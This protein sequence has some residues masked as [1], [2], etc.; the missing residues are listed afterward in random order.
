MSP[1]A[2]LHCRGSGVLQCCCISCARTLCSRLI[3]TALQKENPQPP[4]YPE[5]VPLMPL[6]D[7]PDQPDRADNEG[8]WSPQPL[9]MS[10]ISPTHAS[11]LPAQTPICEVLVFP[12][13]L[14]P[15]T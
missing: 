11:P 14:P 3:T 8:A 2:Y 9:T 10:T 4:P 13:P 15:P 6:M 12:F 7:F 1:G 5:A